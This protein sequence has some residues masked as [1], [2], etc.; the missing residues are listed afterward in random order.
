MN[1]IKQGDYFRKVNVNEIYLC[2]GCNKDDVSGV[3]LR[4]EVGEIKT[5]VTPNTH[6][7]P[8]VL[9]DDNKLK[10]T[11]DI[12]VSEDYEEVVFTDREKEFFTNT[13][14]ISSYDNLIILESNK[15]DMLLRKYKHKVYKDFYYDVDIVPQ[16]MELCFETEERDIL[17]EYLSDVV[18]VI[19]Y[20][21]PYFENQKP[22]SDHN[23]K[24]FENAWLTGNWTQF[25]K[26]TP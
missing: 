19:E 26:Q 12:S 5:F 11:L 25:N 20:I 24:D 7:L 9:R 22:F 2:T 4:Q 17:Y 8:C 13:L 1:D 21:Y 23:I 3:S 18:K 10:Y 16:G 15:Y 14:G 6:L